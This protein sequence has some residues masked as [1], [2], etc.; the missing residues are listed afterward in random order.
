MSPGEWIALVSLAV[1]VAT[2]SVASWRNSVKRD[3]TN[4]ALMTQFRHE[5]DQ[6]RIECASRDHAVW[7]RFDED[8]DRRHALGTRVQQLYGEIKEELAELRGR[9]R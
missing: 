7:Q 5:L 9:Q 6:H 3:A 8:K 1:M 4:D 2:A